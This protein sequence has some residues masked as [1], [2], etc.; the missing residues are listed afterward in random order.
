MIRSNV[1]KH[2]LASATATACLGGGL[3]ILACETPTPPAQADDGPVPEALAEPAGALSQTVGVATSLGAAVDPDAQDGYYLVRKE[4]G[5][6][7]LIKPVEAGELHL[8][9][10][11]S[12]EPPPAFRVKEQ[13]GGAGTIKLR[14][15]EDAEVPKPLIVVDGVILSDRTSFEEIN[16]ED[17]ASV[18]VIKGGAAEQLYG[19]RAKNGV[20]LITTKGKG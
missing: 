19:E 12:G 13:K 8:I 6:V 18:E 7:E 3:L 11:E 14:T 1:R 9:S 4:G 2:R 15:Q 20:I 17:I 16:K 5:M 10:E